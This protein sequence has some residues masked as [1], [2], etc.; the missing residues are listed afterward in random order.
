MALNDLLQK[1]SIAFAAPWQNALLASFL[2]LFPLLS[3]RFHQKRRLFLIWLMGICLLVMVGWAA[4]WKFHLLLPIVFLNVIWTVLLVAEIGRRHS[5]EF[6]ERLK[7]KATMGQYFS[8]AVLE[9]VLTRP[10]SLEPQEATLTLLLTDLRNFTSVTEKF[11]ARN[12]YH[13]LNEVFHRQTRAVHQFGG[14]LEHFFGDQFVAYW[15]APQ[16]TAHAPRHAHQA[17][18]ALI[19]DLL[20]LKE[21][22][23]ADLKSLFDF[24]VALHHGPGVVGNVGGSSRLDYMVLGDVVNA[25]ARVEALTKFYGVRLLATDSFVREIDQDTPRRRI[26]EVLLKGKQEPTKLWELFGRGNFPKELVGQYH[27]AFEAYQGG[28]FAGAGQ[29]FSD[30][31]KN[32]ADGPSRVL[33]ERCKLF[34]EQP[35]AA[36]NGVFTFQTK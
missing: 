30:L 16:K 12:I 31:V 29:K 11:G 25:A 5:E 9:Q 7:I 32:F 14:N 17:A 23:P 6:L 21:S 34:T 27:D 22:L 19:T 8:P 1:S 4:I 26:D 24:G 2:F 3:K 35:P 36:W 28:D 20:K 15:G 18:E 10:G 13:L 33:A